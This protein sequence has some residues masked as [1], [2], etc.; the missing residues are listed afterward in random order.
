MCGSLLFEIGTFNRSGSCRQCLC[1]PLPLRLQKEEQPATVGSLQLRPSN[2]SPSMEARH[3]SWHDSGA[4]P[5]R[6]DPEGPRDI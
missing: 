5:Q 4:L 3:K 2:A 1:L 6:E